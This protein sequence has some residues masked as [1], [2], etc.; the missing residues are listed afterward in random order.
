MPSKKFAKNFSRIVFY[1]LVNHPLRVFQP[2]A[3]G[4]A[5]TRFVNSLPN[6]LAIW[7]EPFVWVSAYL[8][9]S[10]LIPSV[11]EAFCSHFS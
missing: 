8:V 6:I 4:E 2:T 5:T 9:P 3:M 1:I 7:E 11:S 10:V